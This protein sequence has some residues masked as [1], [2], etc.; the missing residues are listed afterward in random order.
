MI[1]FFR[2][3]HTW[4][5]EYE[6]QMILKSIAAAETVKIGNNYLILGNIKLAGI[7]I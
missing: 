3:F 2:L 7:H 6:A 1:K 5:E 4:N